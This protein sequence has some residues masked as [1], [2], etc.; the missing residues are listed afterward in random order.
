ME[1]QRRS[2][3]FSDW[4][5]S[6]FILA[7][8]FFLGLA[9]EKLFQLDG[10]AFWVTGIAAILF[11]WGV[12]LIDW[13]IEW[14]FNRFFPTGINPFKKTKSKKRKPLALVLSLPVGFFIGILGAKFGIGEFLL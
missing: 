14:L 8:G 13:T 7:V 4:I 2:M 9:A 5:N 3:S 11:F 1:K 6:A 12:L 10:I